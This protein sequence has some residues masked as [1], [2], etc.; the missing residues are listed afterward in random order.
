VVDLLLGIDRQLSQ[1]E[2]NLSRYFS[3]NT[4]LTG[5]ALGLYVC[6]SALPEL[7]G[8]RRW[9]QTGRDV[10][11]DQLD[12][13]VCA[14]GGHAERSTHYHRYTLDYYLLALVVAGL[15]GDGCAGTFAE[16]V[17]RLARAARLLA[18][19]DGRL[20]QVG[21]DDGGMLFPICGRDPADVSAPLASA[22]ALLG[23]AALALGNRQYEETCWLTGTVGGAGRPGVRPR[24]LPLGAARAP[25]SGALP[26]TG[27]Y[28]SKRRT[29]DHIVIDGGPHGYLNGGHAHADAL[30]VTMTLARQ[31]LFIDPGTAT[32]TMSA[33]LRDR[34]RSSAMHNTLTIDG[35][36][37]SQP[38]GPFHWTRAAD[39][40]VHR[41]VTASAFDYFEATHDGY[42]PMVHRRCL[43]A[44]DDGVVV[45]VDS[46]TGEGSHELAIHWHIAPGWRVEARPAR[47]LALTLRRPGGAAA[48]F[49]A[50]A[51]RLELFDGDP[52]PGLG[53]SSPTFG[54][55]VPSLTV[56]ASV[57]RALPATIVT[58]IADASRAGLIPGGVEVRQVPE[59]TT[60]AAV[61]LTGR[62]SVRL[63]L[64]TAEGPDGARVG[65]AS[66]VA[67][68]GRFAL[69][70]HGRDERIA[71]AAILDGTWL[72]AGDGPPLVF[73]ESEPGV[74]VAYGRERD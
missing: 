3:P 27:Y 24:A 4:H 49:H 34:F 65:E 42:L 59:E 2:E 33:E 20:P 8:S 67:T 54:H 52:D 30:A 36:S 43:A 7:A 57:R 71:R 61:R 5:E 68:D 48:S 47:P 62:D 23:D 45:V 13:Q 64:F 6:G 70:E 28:V 10:L 18:D 73:T 53:W 11:L 15:T 31:P 9:V 39:A 26:A 58:V 55:L 17:G 40:T 41:W 46:V 32:Y 66:G 19:D 44:L 72:A 56:R 22:A 29:G 16:A 38:A 14:D 35:R 69:V 60:A 37:Q 21:D 25:R 63:L 12:R 74:R 1:V 50:T 51:A